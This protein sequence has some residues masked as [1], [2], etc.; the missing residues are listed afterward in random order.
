MRYSSHANDIQNKAIL[1]DTFK[2]YIHRVFINQKAF[3]DR[4]QH[5]ETAELQKDIV[6]LEAQHK[7]TGISSYKDELDLEVT[8]LKLI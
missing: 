5:K 4:K 1:W 2:G 6:K 7:A 3:V 8:K